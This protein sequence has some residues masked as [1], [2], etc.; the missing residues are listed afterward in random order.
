MGE[1]HNKISRQIDLDPIPTDQTLER[2]SWQTKQVESEQKRLQDFMTKVQ[3][4]ERMNQYEITRQDDKAR[5]AMIGTED[6]QMAERFSL[7]Q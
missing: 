2:R 4:N 1:L 7:D 3:T 5:K 6:A